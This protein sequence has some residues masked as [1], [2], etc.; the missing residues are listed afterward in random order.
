MTKIAKPA[1]VVLVRHG[2]SMSNK[3]K[4]NGFIPSFVK[5]E[6]MDLS[7]QNVPLTP[8]GMKQ[9]IATGKKIRKTYGIFDYVYSSPF[10]RTRETAKGLMSAYTEEERVKIA[11]RENLFIRERDAGYGFSMTKVENEYCFP[12]LSK[13]W[14]VHG[15]FY[16]TPPGGE[17]IAKVAERVYQFIGMLLQR[18][19]A[20]KVL[21]VT[22]GGTIRCFRYILEHWSPEQ[23]EICN[24]EGNPINCGVTTYA[25]NEKNSLILKQYNEQYW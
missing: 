5:D 16:A 24:N 21:I 7:A 15:N 1:L 14:K 13:Y 6:F 22:H 18:R 11:Y 10:T 8:E 3:K 9:A 12:W 25:V 17:S 20:Q 2:E 19:G 4:E 23:A